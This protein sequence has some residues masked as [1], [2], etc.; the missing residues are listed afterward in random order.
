MQLE[1]IVLSKI[2]GKMGVGEI[3]SNSAYK[4]V[5]IKPR[6]TPSEQTSI[7]NKMKLLGLLFYSLHLLWGLKGGVRQSLN[8]EIPMCRSTVYSPHF[9]CMCVRACICGPSKLMLG[10]SLVTLPGRVS[11]SNQELA[12][13]AKL[14]LACSGN[15]ISIFCCWNYKQAGIHTP[16]S[17][18]GFELQTSCLYIKLLN[19]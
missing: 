9:V 2:K 7:K 15:T 1:I 18:W 19:H 4:N 12:N 17:F 16:H 6:I 8:G 10:I 11:Q 13:M 14:Q 3:Q 5:H